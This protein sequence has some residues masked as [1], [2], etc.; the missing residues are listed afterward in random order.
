MFDDK[1]LVIG[2][3]FIVIDKVSNTDQSQWLV[4]GTAKINQITEKYLKDITKADMEGHE[5]FATPNEMLEKY[6]AYYG[7]RVSFDT[8]VKLI[9]FV[10]S[11]TSPGSVDKAALLE[12]AK[13]YT[14]GGSRGNPGKSACAYVICNQSDEVVEDSGFYMGLATNNQAEYLGVQKALERAQELGIDEVKL[15]S[16]SQLIVNQLKGVYKVKNVELAPY[17]QKVKSLSES[18]KSISF[19]HI[20]REMNKLAD[21]LVNDTLDSLE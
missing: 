12:S 20:P 13:I 14:D 1:D 3:E 19:T 6:Q 17:Y 8:P 7:D 2:D 9:K 16:D 21:Q 18:F 5:V 11:P 4:I 10:F 15:F